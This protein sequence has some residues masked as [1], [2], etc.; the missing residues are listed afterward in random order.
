MVTLASVASGKSE[1]LCICSC[2]SISELLN[3]P[4]CS[5]FLTHEV[6][7]SSVVNG[8]VLSSTGEDVEVNDEAFDE[9]FEAVIGEFDVEEG[10]VEVES[11]KRAAIILDE[12]AVVS[13][14][15]SGHGKLQY[16]WQRFL[17][18]DFDKTLWWMMTELSLELNSQGD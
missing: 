7:V 15:K 12:A 4:R 3:S 13:K 6:V 17:Y 9:I 5:K 14:I 2:D 16:F 8:S 11:S 10:P 1:E 18:L